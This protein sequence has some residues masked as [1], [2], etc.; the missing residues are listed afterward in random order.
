MFNVQTDE[1]VY[2]QSAT[3]VMGF[4]CITLKLQPASNVCLCLSRESSLAQY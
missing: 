2:L 4:Q 1:Q 3:N